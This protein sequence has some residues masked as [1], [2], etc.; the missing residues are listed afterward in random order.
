[1]SPRIAALLSLL[2]ALLAGIG[3]AALANYTKPNSLA[4][5]LAGPLLVL[6]VGGLSMPVWLLAQR[7]LTPKLPT[8]L[9]VRTALREGLWSGLYVTLLAGLRVFGYLDWVMVLVLAALFIMLELFL[10]QRQQPPP[11]PK[12]D[13]PAPKTSPSVSYGR[14]K[15]T[16][17]RKRPKGDDS[18]E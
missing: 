16:P 17:K 15:T 3:L 2:I 6:L 7:R 1:M 13:P 4:I 5:I 9:L 14:S 10:Q 18:I 11:A 8:R 12:K